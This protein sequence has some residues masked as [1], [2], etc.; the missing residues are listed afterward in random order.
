VAP[1]TEIIRQTLLALEER[2]GAMLVEVLAGKIGMPVFRMGGFL[3]GLQRV[4]NLEGYQVLSVDKASDTV[5][6]NLDLL[7]TQFDLSKP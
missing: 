6:L 3:S 4:L 7:K 1:S 2:G 5:R